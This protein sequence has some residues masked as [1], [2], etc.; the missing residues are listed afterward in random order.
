V[1]W[2][3]EVLVVG[4]EREEDA[5]TW[6]WFVLMKSFQRSMQPYVQCGL[7]PGYQIYLFRNP[8]YASM[9]GFEL[10]ETKNVETGHGCGGKD[11][12]NVFCVNSI[13]Q[14]CSTSKEGLS[15]VPWEIEGGIC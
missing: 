13:N 3:W 10:K 14:I 5:V 7:M 11:L 12:K 9:A 4:G 8:V 1:K 6:H 15:Q 2:K